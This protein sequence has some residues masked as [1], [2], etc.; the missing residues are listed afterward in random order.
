VSA[1]APVRTVE[2]DRFVRRAELLLD[3]PTTPFTAHERFQALLRRALDAL[4]DGSYGIAAC[5]VIRGHGQE[6]TVYGANRVAQGDPHGHAEMMAVR[7]ARELLDRDDPDTRRE[8][9]EAM[10]D[11]GEAFT[12]SCAATEPATELFSTLEPCPMCTINIVNAHV[13]AVTYA[14]E[15]E[16]A[17]ALASTR[18]GRL[19]ELWPQ[20][21]DR[22]GL[23]VR[24]AQSARPD[25]VATYIP[26]DLLA[27][28]LETFEMSRAA[29]D[30]TLAADGFFRPHELLPIAR[31]VMNRS[32]R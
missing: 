8:R 32:V 7:R 15:D 27:A 29:L 19:A 30:R 9:L 17:G 6:I 21:A 23:E 11:A 16:K 1:T 12:R 4:Q 5:Y 26:E 14:A 24:R 28:L 10:I 31:D 25:L 13:D 18:L 20:T 3:I 22:Q 2:I